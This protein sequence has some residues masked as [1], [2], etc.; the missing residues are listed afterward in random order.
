MKQ[1]EYFFVTSYGRTATVW[2]TRALNL[3][4]DI[5]CSH[6]P[7]LVPIIARPGVPY[8][9]QSVVD[10]QNSTLQFYAQNLRQILANLQEQKSNAR[11]IGN[12]HAFSAQ[13]LWLRAH[14]E[15]NVPFFRTVN[16]LRHP[17]TRIDSFWRRWQ[18]EHSFHSPTTHWIATKAT[19]RLRYRNIIKELRQYHEVQ[20]ESFEE[21]AFFYAVM[22]MSI[23][24]RD[25]RAGV[26]HISSEMLVSDIEYFTYTIKLLMGDSIALSEEY[27]HQVQCLGRQN[28][29]EGYGRSAEQVFNEWQPWQRTLFM[30]FLRDHPRLKTHYEN[31]GYILPELDSSGVKLKNKSELKKAFHALTRTNT[32]SILWDFRGT[33]M[34][35]KE[36]FKPPV[37]DNRKTAGTAIVE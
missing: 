14:T 20:L 27:I 26:Q 31:F 37:R 8:T 1:P 35:N 6:G 25:L 12:I 32:A 18:Q 17:V 10:A 2:L 13:N 23:D 22:Q 3:H 24:D 28:A 15:L 36:F 7:S 34:R 16:L 5:L 29:A 19:Q 33:I 11:W 4:P 30:M 9:A 21:R